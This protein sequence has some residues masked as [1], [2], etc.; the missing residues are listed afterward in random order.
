MPAVSFKCDGLGA[1]E[2][3]VEQPLKELVGAVV[4]LL[5]VDF[6]VFFSISS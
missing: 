1:I 3:R 4:H 2:I 6:H 5:E